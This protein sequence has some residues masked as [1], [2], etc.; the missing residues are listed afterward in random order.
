MEYKSSQ[1]L[2]RISKEINGYYYEIRLKG[3]TIDRIRIEEPSLT[4]LK[5]KGLI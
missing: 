2:W 5:E 3:M 1:K 4:I